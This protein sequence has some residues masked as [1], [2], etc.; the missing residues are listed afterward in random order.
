MY[1]SKKI[2]F[3]VYWKKVQ[4][5]I[6]IFMDV[7]LFSGSISE[8]DYGIFIIGDCQRTFEDV[9][10]LIQTKWLKAD[11]NDLLKYVLTRVC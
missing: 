3:F 10:R 2:Y 7:L 1:V 9:K 4:Y 5:I 11:D 6:F 8:G